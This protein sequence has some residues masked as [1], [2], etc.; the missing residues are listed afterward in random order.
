MPWHDVEWQYT[1]PPSG[2]WR[3][4]FVLPPSLE[5]CVLPKFVPVYLRCRIP[6]SYLAVYCVLFYMTLSSATAISFI[7][8][9]VFGCN[10]PL[11]RAVKLLSMRAPAQVS[12]DLVVCVEGETN[13]FFMGL[14]GDSGRGCLVSVVLWGTDCAVDLPSHS[15][16]QSAADRPQLHAVWCAYSCQC[17]NWKATVWR[18]AQ[19]C[20]CQHIVG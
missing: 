18:E 8:I 16:S 5:A 17:H 14:G 1:Y 19:G 20:V 9:S 10:A 7:A 12:S 13:S 4:L 2:T 11:V 6:D 15:R 3:R